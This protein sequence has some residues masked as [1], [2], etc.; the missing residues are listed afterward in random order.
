M[1]KKQTDEERRAKNAAKQRDWRAKNP[2]KA[3]AA[4]E[5]CR[6]DPGRREQARLKTVRWRE[7]H[8]THG[9]EYRA[10][11][12]ERLRR[13]NIEWRMANV[14]TVR[15]STL[16]KK[17][18]VTKE[19]FDSLLARQDG[20]C[21]ICNVQIEDDARTHVDHDHVTSLVRG[22]LC[23]SCNLGLGHFKDSEERLALAIEYLR[24]SRT[25]RLIKQEG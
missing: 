8:P 6:N 24:R 16:R 2:G 14:K 11:N 3:K 15:H 22:L 25:P 7:A 10:A 5:R 9:A 19:A 1:R 4:Q 21:A 12:R 18:G 13:R 23:R 17:Y 20:R